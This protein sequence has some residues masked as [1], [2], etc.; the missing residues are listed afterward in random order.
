M[1]TSRAKDIKGRTYGR[2]IVLDRANVKDKHRRA[3]WVC[4][5]EC[6]KVIVTSGTSLRNGETQSCGCYATE[7]RTNTAK[8]NFQ[9]HGLRNTRIYRI[10]E[11]M[12]QRCTNPNNKF[13]HC[14]GGRGIKV[15][16]EWDDP[17][18]FY[19]WAVANGYRDDLT[20]DRIDVNRGYSPDNCRW[21]TMKE[22]VKN[23]RPYK[24]H[25]QG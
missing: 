10:W 9:T 24:R 11:A 23:R 2:L 1:G 3:M 7:T 12:R 15:C 22:Q 19:D 8:S 5:C 14:Y 18:A 21:A 6:G 4:R 16:D 17:K 20:I 13:W 25:K